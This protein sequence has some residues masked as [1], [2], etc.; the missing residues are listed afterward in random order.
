MTDKTSVKTKM[1]TLKTA[2][3]YD[4]KYQDIRGNCYNYNNQLNTFETTNRKNKPITNACNAIHVCEHHSS[5][6]S[7]LVMLEREYGGCLGTNSR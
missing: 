2:Y 4:K 6:V 3:K 1:C 5:D 7:L